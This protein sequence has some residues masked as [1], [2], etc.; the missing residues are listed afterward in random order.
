MI[1]S[2]PPTIRIYTL[3]HDRYAVGAQAATVSLTG[4][5]DSDLPR[6]KLA[7]GKPEA[8]AK[9]EVSN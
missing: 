9:G 8:R 7:V 3:S 2:E 5:G 6:P 1:N 4:F